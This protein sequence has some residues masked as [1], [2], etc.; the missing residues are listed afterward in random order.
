M[1]YTASPD[2]TVIIKTLVIS[3]FSAAAPAVIVYAGASTGPLIVYMALALT[4]AVAQVIPVWIVLQPGEV[5][6][7]FVDLVNSSDIVYIGAY[8]AE[9]EGVAD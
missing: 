3:S 4:A 6:S 8:G 2:E 5:I 1:R 7:T 9:L